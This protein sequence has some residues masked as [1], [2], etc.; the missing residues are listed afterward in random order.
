MLEF[1]EEHGEYFI[2]ND[3]DREYGQRGNMQRLGGIRPDAL[4]GS[5]GG[6]R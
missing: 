2:A 3:S 5:V 6:Q 1:R 4:V